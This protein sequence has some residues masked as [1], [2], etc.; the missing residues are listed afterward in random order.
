MPHKSEDNREKSE[1]EM[2][3]DQELAKLKLSAEHGIPFAEREHRKD[4]HFDTEEK[5][6]SAMMEMEEAMKNPDKRKIEELLGFPN[7]PKAEHLTD[8]EISV[9]LELAITILENHYIAVDVIYPTP[10]REVYRF[11]TEEVLKMEAGM[12]G[13]AGMTSHFIYEEHYPNYIASISDAIE[14]MLY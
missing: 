8:E 12:I 7:F 6:W 9:G 11:I 2:N 14:D 5:F 13:V 3:F 10:E 4:D 1:E